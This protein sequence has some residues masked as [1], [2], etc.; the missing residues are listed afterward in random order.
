MNL[1]INSVSNLAVCDFFALFD[2]VF[3]FLAVK[4]TKLLFFVIFNRDSP[5]K[6]RTLTF[7]NV[8]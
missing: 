3:F 6:S 8:E 5:Q 2:S 4:E 7:S 1:F